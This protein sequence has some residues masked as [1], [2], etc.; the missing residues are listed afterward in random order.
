MTKKEFP[1]KLLEKQFGRDME[2]AA[3]AFDVVLVEIAP[4]RSVRGAK[5]ALRRTVRSAPTGAG[6]NAM[7]T[8]R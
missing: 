1:S 4:R 7:R 6:V 8:C 3:E 2:A 5:I